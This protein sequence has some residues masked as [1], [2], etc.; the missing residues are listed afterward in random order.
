MAFGINLFLVHRN[1][2]EPVLLSESISGNLQII[3]QAFQ[4]DWRHFWYISIIIVE[5]FVY[6]FLHQQRFYIDLLFFIKLIS[7]LISRFVFSLPFLAF[8]FV[9]LLDPLCDFV[10]NRLMFD[11]NT[12]ESVLELLE[13]HSQVVFLSHLFVFGDGLENIQ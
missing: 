13:I 9:I 12:Q 6:I 11:G 2:S 5:F 4:G 7:L 10:E 8:F 1:L 3:N